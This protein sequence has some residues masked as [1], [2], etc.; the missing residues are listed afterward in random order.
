MNLSNI[1]VLN[2]KGAGYWTLK[3]NI[4]NIIKHENLFSHIKMG[5]KTL[6]FCDIE[7]EKKNC[8]HKSLIFFKVV[9]FEKEL[10]SNKISCSE[11]IYK[12]FIPYFYNAHKVKSLHIW[13]PKTSTYIKQYDGQTK[14]MYF[15]IANN[16]LL[17]KYK[18]IWDKVSANIKKIDSEPVS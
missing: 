12:Y 2:I 13:L 16:N 1:A 17:E 8:C 10:V 7:I 9:D 4:K 11:K 6:T 15:L 3:K 5:K 18:T 14:L